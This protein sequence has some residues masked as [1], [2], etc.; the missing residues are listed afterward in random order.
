MLTRGMLVGQRCLVK[1]PEAVA[2][3][4][5]QH[6]VAGLAVVVDLTLGPHCRSFEVWHYGFSNKC[7]E[8]DLNHTHGGGS[9]PA[10]AAL[11]I[12]ANACEGDVATVTFVRGGGC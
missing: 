6:E 11:D 9:I 3:L 10:S 8:H 4:V 2:G 7:N 1:I 12:C 5:S